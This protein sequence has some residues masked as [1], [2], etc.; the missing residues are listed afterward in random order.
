[1]TAKVLP[2]SAPSARDAAINAASG[3]LSSGG[4]VALPTDTVYGLAAAALVEEG[5]SHLFVLKGRPRDVELP[6]LVADAEQAEAEVAVMTPS[7]RRLAEIW[8]PGALTL[9][10]PRRRGVSLDLG[11][12]GETVGVRC[13]DHPVPI[14]LCR[15]CGPLAAT[16][17]NLH[18]EPTPS[19][20]REVAELFGER[21]ALVLDAGACE[22]LPSTVVDCT[23]QEPRCLREG[24][25]LWS[26]VVAALS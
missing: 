24:R 21:L 8:W 15:R 20:A 17:A 10:V 18:D 26:D 22:G 12:D 11:G 23:G 1:M 4:V 3:V 13:P 5:P 9:V 2:A 14:A 6:V 7:A 25:V 16:S 19:S